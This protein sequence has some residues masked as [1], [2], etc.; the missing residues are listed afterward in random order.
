ME[1]DHDGNSVR[2]VCPAGRAR[3]CRPGRAVRLRRRRRRTESAGPLMHQPHIGAP[4][5][6]DD[7]E[8]RCRTRHR[9][10]TG[11][12]RCP[13]G[14]HQSAR[15]RSGPGRRMASHPELEPPPPGHRRRRPRRRLTRHHTKCGTAGR[16]RGRSHRRRTHRRQR[17]L[18]AQSGRHAQLATHRGLRLPRHPRDDGG[19]KDPDP[20][21]LRFAR[22]PQ[23]LQRLLHRR[24]ARADG[25]AA[26]SDG[27]RRHRRRR[28]GGQLDQVSPGPAMG[29]V[30]DAAR[31]QRRHALQARRRHPGGN[32]S[33]RPS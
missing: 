18:R 15:R 8:R 10:G 19:G 25:S 27:L 29:P 12:L 7:R 26:L 2:F 20:G 30:A 1:G 33:L 24:P 23:L 14:G 28:T 4:G 9:F 16:I 5:T 21:L 17:Q 6:H 31:R 3:R 11:A 32:L 13:T 22:T